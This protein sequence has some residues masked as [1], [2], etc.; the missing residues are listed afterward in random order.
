MS[1]LITVHRNWR[2]RFSLLRQRAWSRRAQPRIYHTPQGG[3]CS[4]A[5]RLRTFLPDSCGVVTWGW[6]DKYIA[7]CVKGP[8][9]WQRENLISWRSNSWKG[10]TIRSWQL[11]L[12]LSFRGL[13]GS[14]EAKWYGMCFHSLFSNYWHVYIIFDWT[15]W[16]GESSTSFA[17]RWV[18]STVVRE[19]QLRQTSDFNIDNRCY[20]AS[21]CLGYGSGMK[22]TNYPKLKSHLLYRWM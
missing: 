4:F 1:L 5:G 9:T 12:F 8:N 17:I 13:A 21:I 10:G 14:L 7:F 11:T 2:F 19:P 6:G 18:G 20:K 15:S 22:K 3:C 16:L